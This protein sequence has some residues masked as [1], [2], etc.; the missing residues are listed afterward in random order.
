MLAP[1]DELPSVAHIEIPAADAAAFAAA[2]AAAEIEHER[3][4]AARGIAEAVELFI[5]AVP[6]LLALAL[7]LEK[8]RRARLPRTYIV[9]RDG[10]VDGWTDST[11][12]DGRILI[13]VGEGEFAELPDT[14]IT[15]DL[16]R[17]VLDRAGA[18]ES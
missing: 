13:S 2:L 9:L 1:M 8:V 14:A 5:L 4:G 7:M 3:A 12:N 11:T 15:A 17:Q 10:R 16:L 6:S 18:S